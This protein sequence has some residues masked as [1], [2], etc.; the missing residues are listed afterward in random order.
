[1]GGRVLAIR[2]GDLMTRTPG[3]PPRSIWNRISQGTNHAVVGGLIVAALVG[4]AGWVGLSQATDG[5]NDATDTSRETSPTAGSPSIADTT[6]K[7]PP[8]SDTPS[9]PSSER[10]SESSSRS[11][12]V[13]TVPLASVGNIGGGDQVTVGDRI[14]EAVWWFNDGEEGAD[15]EDSSCTSITIEAVLINKFEDHQV[16]TGNLQLIVENGEGGSVTV[17][18]NKISEFTFDGLE[19]GA[20]R[21]RAGGIPS[22]LIYINGTLECSTPDGRPES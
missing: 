22:A 3:Q 14:F 8:T 4:L 7:S 18:A 6:S 12:A 5:P 2:V 19:P 21:F 9:G 1:M 16:S 13:F 10:T 20:F 17:P 11:A 15:A